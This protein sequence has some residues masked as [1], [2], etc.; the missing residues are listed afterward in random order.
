MATLDSIEVD[1]TGRD[2]EKE[3]VLVDREHGPI[4]NR[5]DGSFMYT[6]WC[7][8]AYHS[9]TTLYPGSGK[10]RITKSW[11]DM[12]STEKKVATILAAKKNRTLRLRTGVGNPTR[13]ALEA[14][15]ADRKLAEQAAQEIAG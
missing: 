5:P 15:A 4:V 7:P 1:I 6:D 8:N 14:F 12:S 2:E 9:M 13:Q 3:E 11:K 10:C